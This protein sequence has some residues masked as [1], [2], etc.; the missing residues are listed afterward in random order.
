MGQ[1][2]QDGGLQA[3]QGGKEDAPAEGQEK[4]EDSRLLQ[5][6]VYQLTPQ[7]ST[8]FDEEPSERGGRG[9]E[10]GGREQ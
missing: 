5:R 2:P 6:Q 1:T 3:L 7:T 8:W 10:E 9:V 4:W